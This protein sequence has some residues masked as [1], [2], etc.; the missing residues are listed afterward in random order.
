M[1]PCPSP[2]SIRAFLMWSPSVRGSQLFVL[3]TL[4]PTGRKAARPWWLRHARVTR[5]APGD[6]RRTPVRLKSRHSRLLLA[7]V[8]AS[9]HGRIPADQHLATRALVPRHRMPTSD[10]P[11]SPRKPTRAL[12]TALPAP[13]RTARARPARRGHCEKALN[14]LY[15]VCCVPYTGKRTVSQ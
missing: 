8:G 13:A 3:P 9:P 2:R 5:K 10:S 12:R 14:V 7:S 6:C 1:L 15:F 4:R 11:Q